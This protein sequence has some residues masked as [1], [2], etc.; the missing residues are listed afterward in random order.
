MCTLILVL[1]S[2]ETKRKGD[3]KELNLR[4]QILNSAVCVSGTKALII[5]VPFK[6]VRNDNIMFKNTLIEN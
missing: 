4:Q 5:V 2:V 1:I 6:I 3:W